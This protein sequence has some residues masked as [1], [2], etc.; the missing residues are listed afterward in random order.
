MKISIVTATFNSGATL[1]DT[2]DSIL[3]QTWPDYEVNIIDGGST[4]STKEIVDAYIPRFN[5]RLRWHTGKD[6]GL[7]DAMNKGIERSTGDVIGILNSDDFYAS[8][9]V[10]AEIARGIAEVDAVYGDLDFVD[11]IDTTKTVRQWRGSQ[12]TPGA[13]LKGWHPA[14][15]T[16]YARK[17][18]YDRLGGFDITFDVSAD[19][20]LMLRFLEKGRLKSKYLPM[21]FVRMRMGGESTGSISKI[22]QGNKNVLRAFRKNG[23]KVPP[24][25]LLRR[26]APKAINMIKNKMITPPN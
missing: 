20:E 24:F 19:F 13:F 4:D 10:L 3:S 12:H 11:F 23:F 8:P 7:Y 2:L 9:T 5:G 22:I 6:N 25:Y 18:C 16:F 17:A 14:H 21:T 1:R 15:P 26:L